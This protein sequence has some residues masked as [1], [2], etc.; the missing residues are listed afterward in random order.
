MR[1]CLKE[2]TCNMPQRTDIREASLAEGGEER[3]NPSEPQEAEGGRDKVVMVYPRVADYTEGTIQ[4][5]QRK[6]TSRVGDLA[7]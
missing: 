7:E 2:L 1:D 5:P 3:L 4:P 6:S